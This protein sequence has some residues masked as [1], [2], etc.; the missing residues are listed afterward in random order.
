M[1]GPTRYST[2]ELS[3]SQTWKLRHPWRSNVPSRYEW[4]QKSVHNFGFAG[5]RSLM[6][7]TIPGPRH[8]SPH[9]LYITSTSQYFFSSFSSLALLRPE[10]LYTQPLLVQYFS[11]VL[12]S[13]SL[14]EHLRPTPTNTD[15]RWLNSQLPRPRTCHPPSVSAK[16]TLTAQKRGRALQIIHATVLEPSPSSTRGAT[17]QL[18]W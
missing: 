9:K 14:A 10:S 5:E 12:Y 3:A 16:T 1:L 2:T 11:V 15:S 18:T 13:F 7:V 4:H 6:K 17:R 8:P